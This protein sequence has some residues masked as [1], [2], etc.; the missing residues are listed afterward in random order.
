MS[1]GYAVSSY[2]NVKSFKKDPNGIALIP[3]VDQSGFKR[4]WLSNKKKKRNC[5]VHKLIAL[6][7]I[8][9][10]ENKPEVNHINGDKSDNKITNLEWVTHQEHIEKSFDNGSIAKPTGK[11]HWRYGVKV[12]DKTKQMQSKA[13]IGKRHPKY[14]GFYSID[15]KKYYSA[16]EAEKSIGVNRRTILRRCYN[17]NFRNFSFVP[18]PDKIF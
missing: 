13:K 8:P 15:G 4:V 14:K 16:A 11:D 2:G 6:A 18:D 17:P 3:Y 5:S 1:A 12:S 7:F 9:N 10:P